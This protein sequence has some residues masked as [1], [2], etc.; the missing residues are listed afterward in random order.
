MGFLNGEGWD[1][2]TS[3]G[4]KNWV[5][6]N[7]TTI[8]KT[9]G[10][11][12]NNEIN[13]FVSTLN[14]ECHST[15][16]K[17]FQRKKM[18]NFKKKMVILTFPDSFLLTY[19]NSEVSVEQFLPCSWDPTPS[20]SVLP[21]IIQNYDN[22]VRKSNQ[23]IK[24]RKTLTETQVTKYKYTSIKNNIPYC[25][26][27][28]A[29]IR[30]CHGVDLQNSTISSW[31]KERKTKESLLMTIIL[32]QLYVLKKWGATCTTSWDIHSK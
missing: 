17:P 2:G 10:H 12:K 5:L 9:F 27:N 1:C 18:W 25:S 4:L 16:V 3:W 28:K 31:Q 22:I 6:L 20:L 29:L 26:N 11:Q 21:A 23:T 7:S 15:Y 32:K 24:K 14:K 30:C 8:A 19:Q 13:A